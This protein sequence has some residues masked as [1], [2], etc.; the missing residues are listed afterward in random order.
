M[1]ASTETSRRDDELSHCIVANA[2]TPFHR[3]WCGETSGAWLSGYL[4]D[5][6]H[7]PLIADTDTLIYSLYRAPSHQTNRNKGGAGPVQLL[8]VGVVGQK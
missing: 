1:L 7:S 8:H 6:I 2:Y 5:L 4:G 3:V